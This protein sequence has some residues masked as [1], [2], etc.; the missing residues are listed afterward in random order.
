[1]D[2]A[3]EEA[4]IEYVAEMAIDEALKELKDYDGNC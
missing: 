3:L 1:M 2:R 4:Q